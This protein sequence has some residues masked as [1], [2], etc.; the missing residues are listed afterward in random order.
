MKSVVVCVLLFLV[1]AA[2]WAAFSGYRGG[3]EQ[4]GH[5]ALAPE[6]HSD[7]E[8]QDTGSAL[9]ALDDER[10]PAHTDANG[11]VARDDSG[12][13]QDLRHTS[14][15][16][17]GGLKEL[18]G[19]DVWC[20]E[21]DLAGMTDRE[22]QALKARAREEYLEYARVAKE[23]LDAAGQYERIVTE[24]EQD[25]RQLTG[26]Q[27]VATTISP[28]TIKGGGTEFKLY[29]YPRGTFPHVNGLKDLQARIF[30]EENARIV[31]RRADGRDEE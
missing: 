14:Q 15:E 17:S 1:V 3:A 27:D 8:Y 25:V 19:G 18:G 28:S 30:E 6:A 16:R 29:R 31:E 7:E 2:V 5:P 21:E 22:L 20:V 9:L 13:T 12:E 11:D 24:G 10:V 4:G 23:Q 26:N